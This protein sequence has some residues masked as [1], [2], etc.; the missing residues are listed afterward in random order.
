M[1]HLIE[2]IIL[3]GSS[4]ER[5]ELALE[6]ADL[7]ERFMMEKVQEKALG[8]ILCFVRVEASAAHKQIDRL[9]IDSTDLR[10]GISGTGRLAL[11]RKEDRTPTGG[12]KSSGGVG[13]RWRL[14]LQSDPFRFSKLSDTFRLEKQI[15]YLAGSMESDLNATISK[16]S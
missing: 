9:P 6:R 16:I 3:E 4:Q 2:D 10:K 7:P 1:V 15:L 12:A 11:R 5:T 13:W 8:Q 14:R